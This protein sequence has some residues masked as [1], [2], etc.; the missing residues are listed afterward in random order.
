MTMTIPFQRVGAISN[1]HVGAAFENAA[2]TYFAALGVTLERCH[3]VALGVGAVKKEHAFDLG[4]GQQRIIVECKSHRWTVGTNIPSA[5][6]T[7]WNEAMYYFHLAPRE[8]RKIMFV[9]KDRCARRGV[10][11][12]AYYLGAYSHL[13][14]SD[15]E[16]WEFDQDRLM[17]TRLR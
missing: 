3:R 2:L 12:A 17:A 15:V 8:Y 16:F 5:K 10:T 1:A 11:L 7:V 4:C 14:P 9:L 6:L 13:V